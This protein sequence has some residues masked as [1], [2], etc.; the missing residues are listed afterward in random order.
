MNQ[1]YFIV[2]L[3]WTPSDRTAAKVTS[4]TDGDVTTFHIGQRSFDLDWA[5][6]T[7]LPTP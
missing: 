6:S 7:A 5:D 4:E 2:A 3:S 1:R